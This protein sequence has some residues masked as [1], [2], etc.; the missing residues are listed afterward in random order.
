MKWITL[1]LIYMSEIVRL[2]SVAIWLWYVIFLEF[3]YSLRQDE[4]FYTPFTCHKPSTV[5][6]Q[7]WSKRLAWRNCHSLEDI[8][9]C[10][11]AFYLYWLHV[12]CCFIYIYRAEI[13]RDKAALTQEF[14]W[15]LLSKKTSWGAKYEDDRL[16]VMSTYSPEVFLIDVNSGG[17]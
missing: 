4:H 3:M 8:A 6:E 7:N 5:E 11:H 14:T 17:L 9:L 12:S 2:N 13:G 15:L 16:S 10:W 1:K